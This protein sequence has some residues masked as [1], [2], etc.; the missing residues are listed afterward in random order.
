MS[1][2]YRKASI[3]PLTTLV[4]DD[5]H[6]EVINDSA[7]W[8]QVGVWTHAMEDTDQSQYFCS[9]TCAASF[10]RKEEGMRQL[11]NL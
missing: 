3:F 4:C 10:S 5:C 1:K 11:K 9:L 6:K 7:E 2:L 8:I